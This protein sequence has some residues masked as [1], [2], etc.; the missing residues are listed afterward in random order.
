MTNNIA[1]EELKNPKSEYTVDQIV[2]AIN[3]WNRYIK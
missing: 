3:Y 1:V 2:A